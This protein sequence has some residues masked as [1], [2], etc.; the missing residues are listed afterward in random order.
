MP[1]LK[2]ERIDMLRQLF[3]PKSY[4]VEIRYVNQPDLYEHIA[5]VARTRK[6]AI[7]AAKQVWEPYISKYAPGH[8]LFKYKIHSKRR[9]K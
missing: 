1:C 2:Q 7:K 9:I 3:K 6:Q 8:K 4:T 5:V